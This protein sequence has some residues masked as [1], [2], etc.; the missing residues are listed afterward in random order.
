VP[1]E[2]GAYPPLE[3]GLL[4]PLE[5]RVRGSLEAIGGPKLRAVIAQL[6]LAGG[7]VVSV[8][9]LLLGVWGEE[10]PATARNTLQYHVSVLRRMLSR[11]GVD[12][13]LVTQAPGY[14]LRA[15][16]DVE[17][18]TTA[19]GAGARAREAGKV[20]HAAAAFAD[21]LNAWRG[22]ALAD[23]RDFE[24]AEARAV[25]LEDQRRVC[26]EAWIDAELACGRADALVPQVQAALS[27]NPTRE[28]LWE[29]L[30]IAL[31][32]TGR[33]DAA[34]AAFRNASATL[35]RELGIRPSE[36]LRKVQEA[37]LCHDPKLAPVP[38]L[39]TIAPRKVTSTV[40]VP[41]QQAAGA[42]LLGPS[43]RAVSLG[44]R[45]ITLGR[46]DDCDLVLDDNEVSRRHAQ[47]VTT[48]DGYELV[49]LDSTNGTFLDGRRVTGRAPLVDGARIE[50]GSSSIRVHINPQQQV[51]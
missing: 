21:A 46:Q 22:N 18:F 15:T 8:D 32:R 40:L 29:Q 28:R 43:G 26:L 49:D 25:A 19:T 50:I 36:R 11:D 3:V 33:Q 42:F 14:L 39:R 31:Y 16:T 37:I 12:E 41:V 35:D 34:L 10:L 47:V 30:M 5:L 7:R 51:T 4:G 24:F 45:P 1:S 2:A 9:E 48:A 27:E 6:A 17:R 44:D 38:A 13:R 23:L 20:E